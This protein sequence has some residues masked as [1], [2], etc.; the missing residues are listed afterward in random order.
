MR[1]KSKREIVEKKNSFERPSRIRIRAANMRPK[2]G[3]KKKIQRGTVNSPNSLF[4][5]GGE[6]NLEPLLAVGILFFLLCIIIFLRVGII[7]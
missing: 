2:T 4:S 1:I 3:T 7:K 5:E 6:V